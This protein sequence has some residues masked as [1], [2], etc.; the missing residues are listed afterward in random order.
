MSLAALDITFDTSGPTPQWRLAPVAGPDVA[1][2]V[3]GRSPAEAASL[4]PRVFNLCGAAHASAATAALGLPEDGEDAAARRQ[5]AQQERLRD[6][7]VAVLHDW[8]ALLGLE[9]DRV[10]LRRL[11][12]G[13]DRRALRRDLLAGVTDLAQATPAG[14]EDWLDHG[15]SPA[16][17]LMR[18]LRRRVEPGWGRVELARPEL[19]D[20]LA[21][22]EDGTSRAP[23][24]TT[25]ADGWR[26]AP[27]IAALLARE[28]TSLFL[29]FTA[30]L[31]DLLACLDDEPEPAENREAPPGIGLARA[32]RGLL[33]H[34]ARIERGVVAD[35]RVLAPSA[36]NLAP[37]GLLA[38]MLA[39][40]PAGRETP[41]LARI[42]VA[43]VN[44]CVPVRLR[45]EAR[46]GLAHA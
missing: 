22:L 30:R 20:I 42:A 12:S 5:M 31:L 35:Y 24:E 1:R 23:R 29:R 7:A 43:S 45:V 46:E 28:G 6:H 37:D 26:A 2:C 19:P 15:A 33:V 27:L 3:I 9:A 44:P 36:W 40:L 17:R 8:P 16:A 25:I 10:A 39:T 21:A 41:M 38:R 4:L 18:R 13:R 14:L 34:R 11:G 32:A